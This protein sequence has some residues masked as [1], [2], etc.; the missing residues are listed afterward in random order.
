MIDLARAGFAVARLQGGDPVVFGRA[1]EEIAALTDAGVEWEIIP[2]ITAA[3]ATAA[4][5]GISLTDRRTAAQL[6]LVAGH[7]AG[8]GAAEIPAPPPGGATIAVYMPSCSYAELASRFLESGWRRET[9]CIICSEVFTTRQR[10]I[11]STLQSLAGCDRL[12]APSILIVG[13]TAAAG[14]MAE[15]KIDVEDVARE[16]LAAAM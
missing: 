14:P 15:A 11:R 6:I 10:I 9:P 13:E 2:G 3:S 12:P 7:R 1:G 8:E 4:A 5:A 16:V